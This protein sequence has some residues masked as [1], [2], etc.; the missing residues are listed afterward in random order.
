MHLDQD[1]RR[2]RLTQRVPRL[3]SERGGLVLDVVQATEVRQRLM[4]QFRRRLA[5]PHLQRAVCRH[6]NCSQRYDTDAL[7]VERLDNG[8][9]LR[10]IIQQHH[11]QPRR[12]RHD[13]HV[14]HTGGDEP[15]PAPAGKGGTIE[16]GTYFVTSSTW[17][18]APEDLPEVM[19]DGIRMQ[20]AAPYWNEVDSYPPE[21]GVNY[22]EHYTHYVTTEANTLVTTQLC[23][24]HIPS[25][26]FEYTA[27]GDSVTLYVGDGVTTFGLV[28]TRQ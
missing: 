6:I 8:N 5:R 11:D 24:S 1:R 20:I 23:P 21:N 3:G 28:L 19:L 15:E 9:R 10:L 12:R 4:R 25:E 16:D 7:V 18:E 17:Y 14:S 26:S 27:E 2:L 22:D 13:L